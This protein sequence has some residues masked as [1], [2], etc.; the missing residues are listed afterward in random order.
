MVL[1]PLLSLKY[2]LTRGCFNLATLTPDQKAK[3]GQYVSGFKEFMG[4]SEGMEWDTDRKQRREHFSK[5]FSEEQIDHLTEEEFKDVLKSLWANAMWV[6]KD[7][8]ANKVVQD[9]GIERIRK[10][11]KELLYGANPLHE[12][13]DRFRSMIKGLGISSISEMLVFVSSDRYCLWNRTPINVLPFLGMKSLLPNKV[14]NTWSVDGEGYEKCNEVLSQIKNELEGHGFTHIDF[15]DA[16]FFL[17][18]ILDKVM[19]IEEEKQAEKLKEEAKIAKEVTLPEKLMTISTHEEAEGLLL[20]VG[21]LLGFDTYVS[22]RDRSKPY[23]DKTLGEIATLQEIPEFTFR[24]TLEI[25]REIDVIWFRPEGYPECCFEVEHTTN[26]RDGLLR[27]FQIS[28]LR[29]IK[30]FIIAP[31][32]TFSKFQTEISRMPFTRIRDRYNFK[33]YQELL[34]FSNTAMKYHNQK[35]NFGLD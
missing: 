30:F 23:K 24:S 25:V 7:V 2:G 31:S 33:S 13:Y 14:W 22:S 34:S 1:Y 10:E 6:R 9:N 19:P 18:Y 17:Y 4:T 8:K 21:N 32:E 26:V 16:D 11:F 27:L 28:P 29:G 15:V 20:E 35:R 12:R 5:K 3:V